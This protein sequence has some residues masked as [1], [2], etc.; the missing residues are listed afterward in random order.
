MSILRHIK[1]IEG[2]DLLSERDERIIRDT[3]WTKG[4]NRG[5]KEA[6]EAIYKHYYSHLF[7][8]LLRYLDDESA[9]EDIIQTVFF[10]VWQNR[11]T[12]EPRGTL[13]AYLF[14]AVRNQAL[15]RLKSERKFVRIAEELTDYNISEEQ[16]VDNTAEFEKLKKA[17]QE[18]I[19]NMPKK[20]RHIFLMHRQENLTYKEIAEVLNISIKTVETQ[21]SRSLKYLA[22]FLSDFR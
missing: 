15:I 17:Y 19:A 18:A 10:K 22:E 4:I 5:D 8:F 14:T 9:I 13:K 16:T 21:M 12:I 3:R 1:N 20:R 6:F 11:K 2:I 7:N